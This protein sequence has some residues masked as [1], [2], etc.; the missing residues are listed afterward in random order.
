MQLTDQLTAILWRAGCAVEPPSLATA[1]QVERYAHKSAKGQGSLFSE[2]KHPRGQPDNAGQFAKKEGGQKATPPDAGRGVQQGS[3]EDRKRAANSRK[4]VVGF[5]DDPWKTAAY[6]DA[7]DLRRDIQTME[8]AKDVRKQLAAQG[9]LNEDGRTISVYHLTSSDYTES[10]M[11]GGLIPAKESAPG[12]SWAAEHSK[13]ATYFLLDREVAI[14]QAKQAEGAAVIEARIPITPKSLI[15]ILPDEDSSTN[16]KDGIK[17][18]L[19]GGAIA[20]IGGIP[21][22]HLNEVGAKPKEQ[23]Q[24]EAYCIFND[25]KPVRHSLYDAL[26]RFAVVRYKGEKG[27]G[28]W[29]QFTAGFKQGLGGGGIGGGR[30]EENKHA[31]GGKGTQKGGQF[32]S[33]GQG[34]GGPAAAKPGKQP[35]TDNT[36]PGKQQSLVINGYKYDV[37]KQGDA[38]Y[39][40]SSDDKG[41]QWKKVN[42]KHVKKITDEL[43]RQDFDRKQAVRDQAQ[44]RLKG[45][46][47]Y[48]LDAI[49]GGPKNGH[50]LWKAMGIPKDDFLD[51]YFSL[52]DAGRIKQSD[53]GAISIVAKPQPQPRQTAKQ[54]KRQQLNDLLGYNTTPQATAKPKLAGKL[55]KKQRDEYAKQIIV[56]ESQMTPEQRAEALAADLTKKLEAA[57]RAKEASAEWT[58]AKNAEAKQTL[59]RVAAEHRLP[60]QAL[61]SQAEEIAASKNIQINDWNDA[62]SNAISQS[63]LSEEDV[64][65]IENAGFDYAGRD[66]LFKTHPELANKLNGFEATARQVASSHPGLIGNYDF[67]QSGDIDTNE[68]SANLWEMLRNGKQPEFSPYDEDIAQ[69]AASKMLSATKKDKGLEIPDWLDAAGKDEGGSQDENEDPWAEEFAKRGTLIRYFQAEWEARAVRYARKPAKGQASF[70]W[71]E[72]DESKHPRDEDGKFAPKEGTPRQ[73]RREVVANVLKNELDLD[74]DM[75]N[76][77]AKSING[78]WYRS[79]IEK[80]IGT[81]LGYGAID[82]EERAQEEEVEK[83]IARKVMSALKEHIEKRGLEYPAGDISE[84]MTPEKQREYLKGM[85]EGRRAKEKAKVDADIRYAKRHYKEALPVTAL[86][87]SRY[88]AVKTLQRIDDLDTDLKLLEAVKEEVEQSLKKSNK[89][90][91]TSEDDRKLTKKLDS[92]AFRKLCQKYPYG[93]NKEQAAQRKGSKGYHAV[94]VYE[95]V[96]SL[97]EVKEDLEGKIE[98]GRLDYY[99]G[100]NSKNFNPI[101]EHANI[102]EEAAKAGH[103]L[104]D[105]IVKAYAYARWL[106][107]K[108]RDQFNKISIVDNWKEH[109][110]SKFQKFQEAELRDTQKHYE[111]QIAEVMANVEATIPKYLEPVKKLHDE[112]VEVE[113]KHDEVLAKARRETGILAKADSNELERLARKKSQIE[114]DMDAARLESGREWVETILPKENAEIT[115][116]IGKHVSQQGWDEAEKAIKFLKRAVGK[117]FGKVSA[118]IEKINDSESTGGRA[119]AKDGNM[120]LRGNESAWVV[121]HEF[122][123][124]LDHQDN[125]AIGSLGKAF[126]I[127]EIKKRGEAVSHLGSG[128]EPHEYA[129]QD[130]FIDKYCGKTYGHE[131]SEVLSMGL[132]YLYKD[133]IKFYRE[134][135]EHFK[136]TMAAI[137]GYLHQ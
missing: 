2:E 38:W 111:K 118:S 134:S 107:Q 75:A 50:S 55:T 88:A 72:E 23:A 120:Y 52:A 28:F 45:H 49:K 74:D 57:K 85:E 17:T 64:S 76:E 48:I 24:N 12:Q 116:K 80:A 60:E 56:R 87:P 32:V 77:L 11:Q 102:I 27:A 119:Y 89:G 100:S 53:D 114:K 117:S 106:P 127:Q 46:S 8:F 26:S 66:K 42:D 98:N 13:Y 84:S 4:L 6:K 128:Y 10:I 51:A 95:A 83:D 92:P 122:G 18:L 112:Y 61:L 97:K 39:A 104:D 47:R 44:R 36:P 115:L 7:P 91:W 21:A 101:K 41:G 103:I 132:Q 20:Y 113:A 62:Y 135:P 96:A 126:A 90:T 81:Q 25:A 136:Y 129:G 29:G 99:G 14:D 105:S 1:L 16:A 3:E 33:K 125:N 79:D 43:S 78:K 108:Y 59:T 19:E 22:T 68:L 34:G 63:H 35:K 124:I 9:R 30:F 71:T 86:T 37:S 54:T 123:H 82:R 133:P 131:S 15:R 73:Q 40:K 109:S 65:E 69:E 94:D 93:Y 137:H 5:D 110:E 70:V 67:G 121:V 31:R 130:G 58:K